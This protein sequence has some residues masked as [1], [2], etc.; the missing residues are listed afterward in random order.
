MKTNPETRT[1]VKIYSLSARIRA[2]SVERKVAL[3]S[4]LIFT[5]VVFARSSLAV[6]LTFTLTGVTF[7]DGATASGSFV[8]N[9]STMTYGVF[10][11]ITSDGSVLAGSHYSPGSGSTTGYFSSPDSYIFDNF[12]IDSH[13]LV[14]S[15]G[16]HI[17]GPGFYPLMAGASNGAGSFVDS[18]E[19][20]DSSFDYRLITDGAF[21]VT[22]AS[23]VPDSGG[24]LWLL[25]I[26]IAAGFGLQFSLQLSEQKHNS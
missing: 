23:S 6:P 24:T 11:I 9:P 15:Y 22:S 8:F 1:K 19:F 4:I 21:D 14:L 26:G 20:V 2:K 18:G 12:A 7:D 5:A 17:A 13:Y 10:D 3:L 16:G 25:A